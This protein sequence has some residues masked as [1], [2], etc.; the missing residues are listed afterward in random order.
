LPI[1]NKYIGLNPGELPYLAEVGNA[2]SGNVYL[3]LSSA[4]A[5]CQDHG[6]RDR[7]DIYN[8][9]KDV[10]ITKDVSAF[11]NVSNIPEE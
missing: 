6:S 3:P 8:L 5:G 2:F 7:P 4:Q 10:N 11:H 1:G 9:D